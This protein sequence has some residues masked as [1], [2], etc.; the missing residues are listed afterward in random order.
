[1]RTPS[2]N[3]ASTNHT[4]VLGRILLA[5]ASWILALFTILLLVTFS[6]IRSEPPY[7]QPNLLPALVVL[8]LGAATW[9]AMLIICIRA[10]R[11]AAAPPSIPSSVA[12]FLFFGCALLVAVFALQHP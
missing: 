3:N 7:S 4:Q 10:F 12:F 1:M 8:V 2:P 9:V 5:R 11:T 6:P